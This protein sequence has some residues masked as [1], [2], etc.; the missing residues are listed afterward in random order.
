MQMYS[1]IRLKCFVW[2]TKSVSARSGQTQR[3][4]S[5]LKKT[6]ITRIRKPIAQ[7]ES[8]MQ[9]KE[10][11]PKKDKDVAKPTHSW[12]WVPPRQS[13]VEAVNKVDNAAEQKTNRIN[14]LQKIH[15]EAA[16]PKDWDVIPVKPNVLLTSDEIINALSKMGAI[17]VKSV[18]ISGTLD[19]IEEFIIASGSSTR[20]IRKMSQA[21]VQAL[22]SRNI[23]KAMGY[24]GAEGA[25]DDDWLLIDCFDRVV[26]LLLPKT[27][28]SLQLEQHWA[29]DHQRP[30]VVWKA[31]GNE[32]EANFEKMLEKHPVPESWEQVDEESAGPTKENKKNYTDLGEL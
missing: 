32:Y 11:A 20:H 3:S 2:L 29:K 17:D 5:R 22:K 26:H 31:N 23:T 27:R 4:F 24:T 7:T 8:V 10:A 14:E 13:R 12:S 9:V 6:D 19:N 18:P 16:L 28:A 1:G 21:I 25:K 30:T 15:T